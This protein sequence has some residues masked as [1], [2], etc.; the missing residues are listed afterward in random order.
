MAAIAAQRG[1]AA[2][3]NTTPP[4]LLGMR[5]SPADLSGRED[6]IT[7]GLITF[8]NDLNSRPRQ[9]RPGGPGT[10]YLAEQR[11]SQFL[12]QYPEKARRFQAY[13]HS[14]AGSAR[15]IERTF[16]GRL[17]QPDDPLSM[18]MFNRY[19]HNT[20][21]PAMVSESRPDFEAAMHS[22]G[23][24]TDTSESW[25]SR[26]N[27]RNLA[28]YGAE[29]NPY[30]GRPIGNTSRHEYDH[31]VQIDPYGRNMV[32]PFAE[33]TPSLTD[34]PFAV[35]LRRDVLAR[36]RQEA[37]A[38]LARQIAYNA[39]PEGQRLSPADV[40][41]RTYPLEGRLARARLPDLAS[42]RP[43]GGQTRWDPE[44]MLRQAERHG[45]LDGP[46]MA[47]LLNTSAGRQWLL[48]AMGESK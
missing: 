12:G 43:P 44:W 3:L 25:N 45:V 1:A 17:S 24:R 22:A 35:K 13:L 10:T 46:S 28:T 27:P 14:G 33:L 4:P 26:H 20:G 38:A 9:I 41:Q 16:M 39:S 15:N 11:L 29:F 7:P 2:G 42:I 48:Q 40:F 23:T 30:A 31:A 5:H 47:K 19:T 36:E 37:S 8:V 18:A 6:H 21:M 32:R 34:I